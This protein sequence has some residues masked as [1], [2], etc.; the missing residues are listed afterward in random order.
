VRRL[1]GGDDIDRGCRAE[2]NRDAGIVQRPA[3][4]RAGVGRTQRR[5][6]DV[7]EMVSKLRNGSGQ[8]IWRGSVQAESP[9]S[10]S[11]C[12]RSRLTT[13]SASA[14]VQRRS[15]CDITLVS[16]CST[17]LIVRSE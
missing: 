4:E 11:N 15:N 3:D 14:F 2:A 1:P 13:L 16:A 12:R 9:V 7:D 10:T 8:L 5:L 17:S 6:D